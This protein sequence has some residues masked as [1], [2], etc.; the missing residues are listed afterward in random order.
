MCLFISELSQSMNF[1]AMHELGI[2]TAAHDLP[3]CDHA[4][5]LKPEEYSSH[6]TYRI[7]LHNSA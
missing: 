4:G 7:L 2:T 3:T 6:N 1:V 5:V